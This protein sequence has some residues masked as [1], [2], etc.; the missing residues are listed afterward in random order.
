MKGY[1][2]SNFYCDNCD[3]PFS[4]IEDHFCPNSCRI[5]TRLKCE[6]GQKI[7]C[8]DCFRLCRSR[9][10]FN[11]HKSTIGLQENSLCDRLYQCRTCCKVIRRRECP[12]EVHQCWTTKCPSCNTFVEAAKHRCSLQTIKPQVPSDKLIFFDF[13][14]DQS[15]GEH[16]VNFAVAQ[17]ADGAENIFKGYSACDDFCSWLF[18]R[19][20]KGFTA[21]A[22][23]MKA[24]DGQF[25]M[26]W[27]LRQGTTPDVIPNGSSL[28]S[29]RHN[30]LS[31]R[32]IDSLNFM[33]MALSKLPSCFG[34]SE[35][36]KGYF[37]HLFNR[38]ENQTYRG[39][40]PDHSF[41][42]PDNMGSDA[43]KRFLQWYEENKHLEFDFQKEMLEYCRSD[44][45]ILRR[46]CLEFRQQFLDIAN[47]DPFRYITIASSSMAVFRSSC[48]QPDTIGMVP[49][50]G[51][52]SSTNYSPDSI[53][54]LDFTAEKE[55]I[56]I[57]HALNSTGECKVGG[58]YVD[59]FCSETNTVYQ[60]QGCFFHGCD[61]CF[62]RDVSHPLKGVTMASLLQKTQRT[63]EHLRSLGYHVIECWEHDFEKMKRNDEDLKKFLLSHT[64]RDR[65]VPRDAFYGGRTNAVKLYHEGNAKYVDFTS[66]Y[67]W[68]NKYCK[69]PVGHPTII[70]K[71]FAS[72]ESYFGLI[73]CTI[74]P[75]RQLYLPVLPY[76][77]HNKLMFPLCR[78]CAETKQQSSCTHTEE[79][80][81]LTGTW[82]TEEVK[83]ALRKG[84]E[85]RE[86]H[87]V[88]HFENSSSSLFKS[89]IDLFLKIKQE[90][91]GWPAECVSEEDRLRYIEEYMEKEGVALEYSQIIK[92]LGRRQVAKLILNSFWG[93]WGM[94]C[95]KS[96]LTHV[97]TLPDFNKMF[98]DTT[99]KIKDVYLFNEEVAAIHWES[100][101]HFVPQD[102]STNIFLAAFTT[103][104]ARMKL[105]EEMDKLGESVLYHDTD[106]IIY[107]Q[108]GENDP[109]I[110]NFLGDFTDELDGDVITTFVSGNRIFL[111]IL[112]IIS[113]RY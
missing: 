33:P 92:N 77:C 21:I 68:V 72:L 12:P 113:F 36:K 58:M 52:T 42:S 71:D 32:I 7:R 86:V 93:R 97:N 109:P 95:N 56:A 26:G 31:I 37:P 41:Y 10:C 9:E 89:F 19:Q 80:R 20:H 90:S 76:R 96:Q 5:C 8:V 65:L 94:N 15:T 112:F 75:P 73:K 1:H 16:I 83:L 14:T 38:P 61:T 53:R 28:M 30:S 35:L 18:T 59:G 99:K 6:E 70:T 54:W 39:Q 91:S 107:S 81:N 51:Y 4:R 100:D 105:Y 79:E 46:C 48:I 104:W 60:F 64:V 101:K 87:E 103:S 24:F 44:V 22:H 66:L 84:Y 106:S 102:K 55:G 82:V 25:I 88:Y 67:P 98:A 62:D 17:Y 85:I 110:G 69:Y 57:Q 23:N 2:G 63:T 43:R 34:L 108:N 47:V 3:K 78:T 111:K 74:A 11:A 13:E 50:L 29:I 45:D 49:A 40:M 27:L